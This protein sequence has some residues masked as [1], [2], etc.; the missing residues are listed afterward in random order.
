MSGAATALAWK[1][2][3]AAGRRVIVG[4]SLMMPTSSSRGARKSNKF[5][6][7]GRLLNARGLANSSA[8]GFIERSRVERRHGRRIATRLVLREEVM[9]SIRHLAAVAI[10]VLVGGGAALAQSAPAPAPAPVAEPQAKPALTIETPIEVLVAIPKARAVL[11][12]D[13]PGLTEHPMYDKFK[14]ENLSALAPKFGGAISDKDLAKVQAD[15]AA[16]SVTTS[17][18]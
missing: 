1:E 9:R 4:S 13:I 5:R 14:S 7:D 17:S 15:L 11:D 10:A 12:A 8:W 2:P 3:H 6:R 18:R 16:L